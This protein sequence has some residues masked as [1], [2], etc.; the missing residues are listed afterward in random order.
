MLRM[1]AGALGFQLLLGL[2]GVQA[3][4]IY[5]EPGEGLPLRRVS[6][7]GAMQLVYEY[8]R[9]AERDGPVRLSIDPTPII[10]DIERVRTQRVVQKKRS[11]ALSTKNVEAARG[12]STKRAAPQSSLPT[13]PISVAPDQPPGE[14]KVRVIPL[15]KM[16]DDVQR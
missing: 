2:G 15:F 6:P 16:P 5:P 3:Q 4:A 12:V 8:D 1:G 11:A 9:S 10:R 13:Q 7:P 14:R